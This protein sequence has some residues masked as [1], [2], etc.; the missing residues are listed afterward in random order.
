MNLFKQLLA[1]SSISL[2]GLPQR[3]SCSLVIIIG[4]AGVVGVLLS[5]LALSTGLAGAMT[6]TGST[7]RAIVLHAQASDEVGSNLAHDTSPPS[8]MHR[9]LPRMPATGQSPPP[10][11]YPR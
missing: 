8:W 9:A 5:V 3:K 11:R 10:R 6:A 1:V 7:D 2:R 4:T